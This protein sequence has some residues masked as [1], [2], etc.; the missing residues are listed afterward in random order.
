MRRI[1]LLTVL[2]C[3]AMACFGL[4][5]NA[6]ANSRQL[7]IMQDDAH[8]Y[9]GS[10]AERA[11]TLDEMKAL[12]AD[13]VKVQVY[14]NEI[15]PGPRK[16]AGFDGANPANYNWSIYDSIVQGALARGMRPFLSLGGRAPQWATKKKTKRNNGTYRPSSREFRLFSQAAGRHFPQVHIWSEWNEVNLS[17]WLQPQRGKHGVPLSPS[18]YR[19]LYLS[20]HKGLVDSGHGSDTILL[21]ELMP[22]GRG[23]GKKFPPLDFLREMVCLDRHYRQYRGGAAKRRGC[24]RV[25]RIPT[26]GIALHPYTPRGGLRKRPKSGDTSI[27]TLSRLTRTVDRLA[28]HRKFP[29]RLPIWITEF[30]FQTNPPDPFQYSIKKVPGYLDESEWIAFRNSRVRSYDQY[31]VFD[32]KPNSGSIFRRW[33]GFQQGLRFSSGKAKP[34]VYTAFR[35]PTF[36][37]ALGS[38]VE[39]FGGLRFSPGTTATVF[40]RK[41]G[42]S[43][44][45]LGT[46][47]LNSAGY[48]RKIFRVSNPGHRVYRV[49]I[50]SYSRTKHPARR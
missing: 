18:I 1:T 9:R 24:K 19:N 2:A 13:V 4:P 26:S 47:T 27:T 23:S 43:Y 8:L 39:V 34:G 40:S 35:M 36:V 41:R 15:A 49:K 37:R 11:S 22:L 21:G 12:G 46:A 32:D 48:F 42:G 44:R 25:K 38:A 16:P 7:L 29:R 6:S 30:G 3:A 33:A 20:G 5:G 45:Q 28:R 14:W 31:T 50:G 10:A 17:S